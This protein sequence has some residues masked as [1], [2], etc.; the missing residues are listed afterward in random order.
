MRYGSSI[1]DV[2]KLAENVRDGLKEY[3]TATDPALG[4]QKLIPA[5]SHL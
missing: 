4:L 3:N 5:I 2:N 1:Q